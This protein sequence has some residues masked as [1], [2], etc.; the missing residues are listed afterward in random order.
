MDEICPLIIP[1]SDY[2]LNQSRD[3]AIPKRAL[4]YKRGEVAAIER[5]ELPEF[6]DTKDPVPHYISWR[7]FLIDVYRASPRTYLTF[8][9][10]RRSLSGDAGSILRLHRFLESMGLINYLVDP[11]QKPGNLLIPSEPISQVLQDSGYNLAHGGGIFNQFDPNVQIRQPEINLTARKNI[12]SEL[13]STE[14]TSL[15]AL[16]DE[17]QWTDQ[18]TLMLLEAIET[19][20]LDWTA[21]ETHVG[22]KLKEQCLLHF[23]RMPINDP[24]LPIEYPSTSRTG[25]QE[26]DPLPYGDTAHP[27]L[28]KVTLLVGL[29]PS[30]I[31]QAAK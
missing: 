8:T 4:W 21:I 3:I 14:S 13:T 16:E 11:E 1:T 2:T 15:K 12:T 29:V 26:P 19:Y 22:T 7:D 17:G 30:K 31:A 20:G 6:F 5:D 24:Y 23:L 9:A 28:G 10:A 18:E 27:I 25:F